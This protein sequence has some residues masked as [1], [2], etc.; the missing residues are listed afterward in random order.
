MHLKLARVSADL[1][2]SWQTV[3]YCRTVNREG[4][5][6]KLSYCLWNDE[7]QAAGRA[8]TFTYW[9]A[10]DWMNGFTHVNFTTRPDMVLKIT[11]SKCSLAVGGL[12][13][14]TA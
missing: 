8:K 13:L 7:V 11:C 4:S 1:T 12:P 2:D 6:S 5:V 3:L 9:V 14:K 10:A